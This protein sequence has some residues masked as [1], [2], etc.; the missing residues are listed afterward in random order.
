MPTMADR[1]EKSQLLGDFLREMAVL[2][3]VLYPLDAAL[4]GKF[5]WFTFGLVMVFGVALL[6][7]GM[8]L[9]GRDEL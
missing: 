8:I 4:E 6:Y 3:V 5:D 9:E 2:I 1:R 7:W